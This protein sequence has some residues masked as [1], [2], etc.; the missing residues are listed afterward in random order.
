MGEAAADETDGSVCEVTLL[1]FCEEDGFVVA[2]AFSKDALTGSH[3]GIVDWDELW[4]SAYA[5]SAPPAASITK[6]SIRF[7]FSAVS[8]V[9][10]KT[11]R[12]I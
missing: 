5:R 6:I 1:V 4:K 7:L 12:L 2:S 8:F 3:P 10:K 11:S 9:I